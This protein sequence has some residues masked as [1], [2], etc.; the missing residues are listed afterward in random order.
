MLTY[1]LFRAAAAVAR[2]LPARVA[3][4]GARLA[5]RGVFNLRPASRHAAEANLRQVVG[6][7]ASE[8]RVTRLAR[9]V[10]EN[11]GRYYVDLFRMP[12]LDLKGLERNGLHEDGYYEYFEPAVAAGK[13]VIIFSAHVGT[14]E[15]PVQA[16]RLRGQTFVALTEPLP[17]RMD[18]LVRALRESR[19]NRFPPV[20]RDGLREALRQLRSGG[21]V[22]VLAD[23]DVLGTGYRMEFFGR[24]TRLPA[25]AVDLAR[26]TGAALMPAFAHRRDDTTW[27]LRILPPLTLLRT[28]DETVDRAAN[29]RLLADA[30]E[31]GIAADPGQWIALSPVWR[32]GA[33]PG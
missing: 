2:R 10:F 15:V 7:S 20:N 24:E 29:M 28:D 13:G 8:A 17:P 30:L 6:P 4:F 31:T 19:G 16:L 11:V 25:G 33:A 27:E 9:E 21:T 18:S 32:N 14:P 22:V 1:L 12:V 23:R 3:Y 26:R 5:A